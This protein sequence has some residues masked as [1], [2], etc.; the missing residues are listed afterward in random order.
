M[1]MVV[2]TKILLWWLAIL[3]LAVL[4]GLLRES[5]LL[6]VVGTV[7][8]FITSGVILSCCIFAVAWLALA[9]IR[10]RT[11]Q[12]YWWMGV[13]WLLLTLV[14]EF[15]FGLGVQHQDMATLLAAY[16]FNDGNIWPVVLLVTLVSPRL[17]AHFRKHTTKAP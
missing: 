17:A 4:N 3:P 2:F 10:L 12:H 13:I 8:A 7:A 6:P 1:N 16:T 15:A 14:F 11:A 9:N 5:V